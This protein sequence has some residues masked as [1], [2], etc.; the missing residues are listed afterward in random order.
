MTLIRPRIYVDIVTSKG[1]VLKFIEFTR[2]LPFSTY[3]YNE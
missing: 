2:A 1:P 3:K